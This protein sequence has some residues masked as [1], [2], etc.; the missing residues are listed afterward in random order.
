MGKKDA[1]KLKK[2]PEDKKE[3][4]KFTQ[5]LSIDSLFG[6]TTGTTPGT[7]SGTTTEKSGDI[8]ESIADILSDK[9]S[10]KEDLLAKAESV[11]AVKSEELNAPPPEEELEEGDVRQ[12]KEEKKDPLKRIS[13]EEEGHRRQKIDRRT[14]ELSKAL[15]KDEEGYIEEL[16]NRLSQW[17]LELL[18]LYSDKIDVKKNSS[19][20]HE[21]DTLL[22]QGDMARGIRAAMQTVLGKG[23]AEI[24]TKYTYGH[25]DNYFANDSKTF[26]SQ[27]QVLENENRKKNPFMA[28]TLQEELNK[29]M[30]DIRK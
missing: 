27:D 4:E 1:E 28:D 29:I 24:A 7:K 12:E 2:E 23:A 18:K 15:Y 5:D 11:L 21:R 9:K 10:E 19:N 16:D 13:S 22:R 20:K 26:K 25:M 8:Q 30:S 14:Q 6:S 3:P 17:S